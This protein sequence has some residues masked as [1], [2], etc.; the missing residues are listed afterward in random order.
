MRF[1]TLGSIAAIALFVVYF[2]AVVV[3][4]KD[5]PLALVVAGGIV[6]VLVDFRD[7]LREG[8]RK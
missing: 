1:T 3:K 6:L 5:V 7:S 8:G 2:G 4:L